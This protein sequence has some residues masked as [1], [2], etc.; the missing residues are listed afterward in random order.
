[1]RLESTPELDAFQEKVRAFVAEHAPTRTT[2]RR[3][4]HSRGGPDVPDR[5]RCLGGRPSQTNVCLA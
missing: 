5:S 3:E 2:R 1:M 4:L